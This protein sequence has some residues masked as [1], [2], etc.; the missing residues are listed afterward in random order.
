MSKKNIYI[1]IVLLCIF[2]FVII[3]LFS[4]CNKTNLGY[5][6]PSDLVGTWIDKDDVIIK[7]SK[8]KNGSYIVDAGYSINIRLTYENNHL[9][10]SNNFSNNKYLKLKKDGC[11]KFC[12]LWKEESIASPSEYNPNVGK[13]KITKNN[14]LYK[15]KLWSI[16]EWKYLNCKSLYL[17]KKDMIIFYNWYKDLFENSWNTKTGSLETSTK[18]YFYKKENNKSMLYEASIYSKKRDFTGNCFIKDQN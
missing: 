1:L 10:L 3:Y 16:N 14:G 12:G 9:I 8:T 15:I 5:K 4:N 17:K 18:K 6:E 13:I 11:D 7:I 2:L